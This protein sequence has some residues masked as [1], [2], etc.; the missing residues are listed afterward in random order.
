MKA[1]Q[2]PSR[3]QR[4]ED[5]FVP[6]IFI[7]WSKALL[8]RAAPQ[9]SERVLDLA[10]GTGIIARRVAEAV[11]ATG[12]VIGVDV[13]ADMLDVARA[14]PPPAGAAIDWREGSATA[15][16]VDD[17]AV[18]LV[19]CQQGLQFFPD[20]R[21]A[22]REALRTL[23]PGGRLALSVWQGLER[24][25]VDRAILAAAAR[26]LGLPIE[27]VHAPFSFGEA[28]ALKAL[29]VEAGFER[30]DVAAETLDAQFSDPERYVELTT[31]A[32]AAV[33]PALAREDPTPLIEAVRTE[34]REVIERHRDGD[35]LRFPMT[36]N[37]AVAYRA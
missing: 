25:D 18:D 1:P 11:G 10:C 7:P 24:H 4:Y 13:N 3:A 22:V 30:V 6:A 35:W 17:E 16:P 26:H 8:E 29:L 5:H 28:A 14:Q 33:V 27:A 32:A 34:T 9:P 31:V 21:A 12:H 36:A 37:V 19:L 20:R 2:R 23:K 15:P